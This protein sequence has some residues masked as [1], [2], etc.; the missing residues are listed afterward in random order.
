MGNEVGL[1]TVSGG[2][3]RQA[4]GEKPGQTSGSEIGGLEGAT[5]G[6]ECFQKVGLIRGILS[7]EIKHNGNKCIITNEISPK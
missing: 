6:G 7:F 1:N 4:A 3:M 2:S 5:V